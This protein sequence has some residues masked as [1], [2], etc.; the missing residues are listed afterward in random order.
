MRHLKKSPGKSN[1]KIIGASVIAL[2]MAGSLLA[3]TT[4]LGAQ[5]Q[6]VRQT[7]PPTQDPATQDPQQD[8]ATTRDPNATNEPA[9]ATTPTPATSTLQIQQQ[10]RP[11][12]IR[13]EPNWEEVSKDIAGDK[14]RNEKHLDDMVAEL[15]RPN[16]IRG[17]LVDWRMKAK[18][19]NVAVMLPT[20]AIEAD[21]ASLIV[22]NSFYSLNIDIPEERQINVM[23]TCSGIAPP[24]NSVM[25]QKIRRERLQ[26]PTL[27]RLGAQYQFN[28]TEH[29]FT[30]NFS[31]FGC[32]YEILMVCKTPCDPQTELRELANDLSVINAR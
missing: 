4:P 28:E 22:G 27:S 31:K 5:S 15:K 25:A 10:G 9:V 18:P 16:N 6:P 14:I 11:E 2:A 1:H 21:R 3:A 24:S 23:G 20:R 19:A 7:T 12:L 29:G 13:I 32:G 17:R 8:P 30:L 26:R